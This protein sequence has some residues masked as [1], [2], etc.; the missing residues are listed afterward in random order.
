MTLGLL[1]S[2][3]EN[4]LFASETRGFANTIES[5]RRL[6]SKGKIAEAVA[7]LEGSAANSDPTGIFNLACYY[8]LLNRN[9]KSAAYLVKLISILASQRLSK[10]SYQRLQ[11]GLFQDPD[12][13]NVFQS[14]FWPKEQLK[15]LPLGKALY[16]CDSPFQNIQRKIRDRMQMTNSCKRHLDCQSVKLWETDPGRR[17]LFDSTLLRK[18]FYFEVSEGVAL[19]LEED[20]GL[21]G[22]PERLDTYSAIGIKEIAIADLVDLARKYNECQTRAYGTVQSMYKL[23]S[24]LYWSTPRIVLEQ[25]HGD[26]FCVDRRCKEA[27]SIKESEVFAYEAASERDPNFAKESN[28]LFSE[29]FEIR[30]SKGLDQAI[31]FYNEKG[32]GSYLV[33]PKFAKAFATFEQK[34]SEH[35][36]QQVSK[37]EESNRSL[38]TLVTSLPRKCEVT[39][40]CVGVYVWECCTGKKLIGSVRKGPEIASAISREA[41]DCKDIERPVCDCDPP[42]SRGSFKC[43]NRMCHVV[44][45]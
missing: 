30:D 38:H 24:D 3:L 45:D 1:L 41:Q 42:E 16:L 22:K 2:I 26:V 23:Q 7:L 36:R 5:A 44:Y 27:S 6:K 20:A 34:A 4:S 33:P 40:D 12:L 19:H 29:L 39:S 8:S 11:L 32:L 25:R 15:A 14:K 28:K 35:S 17:L 9:E 13:A 21:D 37:C 43:I 10:V 31:A 18:D